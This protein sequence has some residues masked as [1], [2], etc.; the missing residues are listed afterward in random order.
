[1]FNCNSE[2]LPTFSVPCFFKYV[3][4]HSINNISNT[5][6]WKRE[7]EWFMIFRKRNQTSVLRGQNPYFKIVTPESWFSLE[8]TLSPYPY[9]HGP[10]IFC[11]SILSPFSLLNDSGYKPSF[12]NFS[13][14]QPILSWYFPGKPSLNSFQR[15]IFS[16][17]RRTSTLYT[18]L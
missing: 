12:S 16:P 5:V 15:Y 11:I 14:W 17:L 8:Q 1:M 18:V 2:V 3:T 10:S 9:C 13:S 6:F 7:F 4:Y